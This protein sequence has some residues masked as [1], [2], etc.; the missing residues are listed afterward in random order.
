LLQWKRN[1]DALVQNE[2]WDLLNGENTWESILLGFGNVD[3]EKLREDYSVLFHG[4]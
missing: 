3:S 2:F 4:K 1:K